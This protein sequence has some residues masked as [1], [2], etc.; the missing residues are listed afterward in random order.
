V[1]AGESGE[2]EWALLLLQGGA[3]TEGGNWAEGKK[4]LEDSYKLAP[5][6]PIVLNYLGYAQLERRENVA[7]A[8]RL[9]REANRLQPDNAAITDSLGWAHF[10][11]GDLPK[12]IELLERAAKGQPADAAIKEHL[13]DAYFKAGRRYEARYA[14]QAALVY[15][16]GRALQRLNAKVEAGLRPDLAAP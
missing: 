16:E 6:Q 1:R 14:W 11:R 2:S 4:R 8:E 3:L 15:A 13:G 5:E 7:E 9:I 10:L 12:A